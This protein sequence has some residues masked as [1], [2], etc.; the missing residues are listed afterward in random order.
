ML[1]EQFRPLSEMTLEELIDEYQYCTRQHRS[2]KLTV[3][4]N[5]RYMQRCQLGPANFAGYMEDLAKREHYGK[6]KREITQYFNSERNRLRIEAGL[7]PTECVKKYR[8]DMLR[9][10]NRRAEELRT[11]MKTPLDPYKVHQP[12]STGIEVRVTRR[13]FI[14][15]PQI[16]EGGMETLLA[17]AGTA[18][19]DFPVG[20]GKPKNNPE[21]EVKPFHKHISFEPI[22]LDLLG[23]SHAVI[24][25]WQIWSEGFQTS[26]ESSTAKLLDTI[27]ATS[28]DEAVEKYATKQYPNEKDRNYW[29]KNTNGTWSF[30][31]CRLYDNEIDARKSFG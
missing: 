22:V 3:R 16:W 21:V 24:K 27:E 31:G 13:N 26:G 10:D 28:F 6:R 23:L 25:P 2:V 4:D 11:A 12:D 19:I 17:L 5:S 9:K 29:F 1:F 15:I 18:H 30:W 7:K 20:W 14:N 8:T